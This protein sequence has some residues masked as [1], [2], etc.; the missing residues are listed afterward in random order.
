MP[1]LNDA[2]E[3]FRTALALVLDPDT[4]FPHIFMQNDD[5]TETGL[6][7]WIVL[8]FDIDSDP[9]GVGGDYRWNFIINVE[10]YHKGG[11]NPNINYKLDSDIW[12]GQVLEAIDSKEF[13]ILLRQN[14]S[15]FRSGPSHVQNYPFE[16]KR[17]KLHKKIITTNGYIHNIET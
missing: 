14:D 5:Y 7:K 17:P 16:T 15:L 6:Q 1:Q 13:A 11:T 12:V 2:M 4:P 8:I 9:E 10:V 3:G